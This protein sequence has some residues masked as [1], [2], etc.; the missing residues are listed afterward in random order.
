VEVSV[1]GMFAY[2]KKEGKRIPKSQNDD[3]DTARFYERCCKVEISYPPPLV[4]LHRLKQNSTFKHENGE[5]LNL[6]I[7]AD[8]FIRRLPWNLQCDTFVLFHKKRRMAPK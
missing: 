1:S 4:L 8:V 5:I 7:S 3:N 2:L 6:E